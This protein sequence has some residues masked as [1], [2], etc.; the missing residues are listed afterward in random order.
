MGQICGAVAAFR[1]KPHL[2]QRQVGSGGV[3]MG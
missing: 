2:L 3:V 1:E